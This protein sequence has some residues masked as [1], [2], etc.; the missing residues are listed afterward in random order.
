MRAGSGNTAVVHDQNQI[1]VL[2]GRDA[3]R[4]DDREEMC[5]LLREGREIKESLEEN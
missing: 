5:R 3:L 4:N 1:R 2:H